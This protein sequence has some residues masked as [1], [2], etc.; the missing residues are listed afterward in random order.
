MIVTF[1][2][3]CEKK[4]H[5][6]TRRV[7]DAFANRI[8]T[9]TWQTVITKEGLIAVQKLLKKTASKNTAV[10]CHKIKS[11][12]LTELLWI[13]GNKDT[14]NNEGYVA[15]NY[16]EQDFF[17]G[18]INM[19]KIYANTK[20][21]PLDQHLFA[22]GVA[23]QEI[24]KT[25]SNDTQ[26][27]KAA[28][29]AG[30]WHDIGK[31]EMHFQNWLNKELKKK[32][33]IPEVPN[34]GVHIEGG[35][36]FTQFS[37]E[38]YPTHNEVSILLYEM[39]AELT[40]NNDLENPIKHAIY[41]H[42][43]EPI[44]NDDINTISQIFYKLQDNDIEELTQRSM[45]ILKNINSISNTYFDNEILKFQNVAN[46]DFGNKFLPK[47]KSYEHRND[48]LDTYH[49]QIKDN[50]KNNLIRTAVVTADR[51]VSSLSANDL[52]NYIE[53][54]SLENF[55]TQQLIADRGLK[56]HIK[57]CLDTFEQKYP[58]SER[59][60]Q[61]AT[62]AEELADEENNIA[63]LQG[64]AGCGKTKIALEWA[65][66]ISAKQI[67]WICPRIAICQ[68]LFA[69]LS[70]DEYL[71]NAVIEIHTGEFKYTNKKNELNESEYFSGNIVLTTIDQ[72][73]N[74]I[75]THRNIS[76]LTKF[77]NSTVI[78]DE[79]HE[80]INMS[81]F[82]LFFAELIECKKTQQDEYHTLPNTLLV[83]ATP[84]YYFIKDFL[85]IRDGEI[86]QIES[87]NN[88]TYAIKFMEYDE[89]L[90]DETNPLYKKTG[91]NTF[92]ISN[93][94]TTAQKSFIQNQ[95]NENSLLIHSKFTPTDRKEIFNNV[96]D[97]FNQNGTHIFDIVRSGPIIQASLNI[98]CN[99]MISE[100]DI[101][102]NIL[103]RLGRLNRFGENDKATLIIAITEN[104]KNGKQLGNS[105]KFLGRNF[106]L[107][108]T[109]V[110]YE[111]LIHKL[112]N[113]K[114]IT[115]SDLYLWY[116]EFYQNKNCKKMIA[117]DFVASLKDSISVINDTIFNPKR[118]K[119]SKNNTIKIKKH[120]LRG[121]SRFV[122]MAIYDTDTNQV[123]NDY[124]HEV[125]TLSVNEIKNYGD[126]NSALE[127]MGKKHHNIKEELAKNYGVKSITKFK[128]KVYLNKSRDPGLPIY[129]SYTPQD[130]DK[131][132]AQAE[133]EAIY[134]LKCKKQAIG[135]MALNKLLGN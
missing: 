92:V 70:G 58:N 17:I 69:D 85:K 113:K 102:E 65:L 107:Q 45:A 98:S 74:G 16:T 47:H 71:P 55:V 93:T 125:I 2:S 60:K 36:G 35:R 32:N 104:I 116:Q 61:Q 73:I 135:V 84:N 118:I 8:G 67:I 81:G 10:S 97:S 123:L 75:T 38:K 14:F 96:I 33:L 133:N 40:F 51:L 111:L 13:V 63:V 121:N 131:I 112:D 52:K 3:E 21:Q 54:K 94:A 53:N 15:V 23:A 56:Q 44:R 95:A 46:Q 59:N 76:T 127:F 41:W 120:S 126:D 72:I 90:Q 117:Q 12:Q 64:P 82:N 78:F 79:F 28:F 31:L 48:N 24:M 128:E 87:F 42:H 4:A 20:K 1:I 34:E 83:S 5:K 66:N 30:C 124:L 100:I 108:S 99:N 103:Q 6:R 62:V 43:A 68:S 25:F 122:Q 18:E 19:N 37:W 88:K 134:Y 101:A 130:L 80:Y 7:L 106:K 105:A 91:K 22:V 115:I 26:L 27:Q 57:N 50:A 109:K 9:N 77:M 119:L 132:K 114:D 89:N 110:W 49:S 86:K 29:I 129:V 11:R 39:L